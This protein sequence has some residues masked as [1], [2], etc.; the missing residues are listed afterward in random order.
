MIR[1][2]KSP[3]NY[4]IALDT[5]RNHLIQLILLLLIISSVWS[6]NRIYHVGYKFS[7]E[8]LP[9][10]SSDQKFLIENL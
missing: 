7:S 1:S 2:K 3:K 4:H 8:S 9:G 10:K 5:T 6:I